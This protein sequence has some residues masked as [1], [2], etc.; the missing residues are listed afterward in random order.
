MKPGAGPYRDF[1]SSV[2]WV[3]PGF[4]ELAR[5]SAPAMSGA[6]EVAWTPTPSM[7]GRVPPGICPCTLWRCGGRALASAGWRSGRSWRVAPREAPAIRP[8]PRLYDPRGRTATP[9]GCSPPALQEAP[10]PVPRGGTPRRERLP[11]PGRRSVSRE[12]HKAHSTARPSPGEFPERCPGSGS[13]PRGRR[14][15]LPASAARGPGADPSAIRL[16]RYLQPF[17]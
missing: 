14:A 17:L 4:E 7:P 8:L 12:P 10:P 9:G 6:G 15:A 16:N 3:L 1:A 5:C 11:A 2:A 13:S